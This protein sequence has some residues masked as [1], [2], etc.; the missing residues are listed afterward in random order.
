MNVCQFAGWKLR[1]P[2]DFLLSRLLSFVFCI[3]Y[4]S[5]PHRRRHNPATRLELRS[6]CT[7]WESTARCCCFWVAAGF[8]WNIRRGVR[9]CFAVEL[10]RK[11]GILEMNNA[12]REPIYNVDVI[13]K[14]ILALQSRAGE[15]FR[16]ITCQDVK[17]CYIMSEQASVQ[18]HNGNIASAFCSDWRTEKV[19]V[20][21]AACNMCR[22]MT[23]SLHANTES[24]VFSF[25]LGLF[26]VLFIRGKLLKPR[27][28]LQMHWAQKLCK[29]T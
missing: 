2:D 6:F 26:T 21:W 19:G 10:K 29:N 24:K 7:N 11:K 16:F 27:A 22:R 17:T 9:R 4:C 12:E 25:H 1:L 15:N 14:W 8:W 5:R 18:R 13:E 28:F 20:G 23:V 3:V